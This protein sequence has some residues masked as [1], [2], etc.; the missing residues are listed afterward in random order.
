MTAERLP[1]LDERGHGARVT[2]RNARR[3]Y[4]AASALS[5][6]GFVG[7]AAALAETAL[8]E[9]TKALALWFG[10]RPSEQATFDVELR[11]MLLGRGRHAARLEAAEPLYLLVDMG[12][13]LLVMLQALVRLFGDKKSPIGSDPA[14]EMRASIAAVAPVLGKAW[15]LRQRGLYV[16]WQD[17]EWLDPA[18]V[19]ADDL[20]SLMRVAQRYVRLA[21]KL[22]LGYGTQGQL[23]L[24]RVPVA[25]GHLS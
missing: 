12:S 22:A 20:D 3:L 4:L 16:D 19:S 14:R 21:T 11:S 5:R 1:D 25:Q 6:R 13:L 15:L 2:A 8:E 10:A 23:A 9:A 17:E 24:G 7:P 18:A